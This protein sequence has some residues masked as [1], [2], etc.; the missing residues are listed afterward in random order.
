M[1]CEKKIFW[2]YFIILKTA[3]IKSKKQ[4]FKRRTKMDTF[5]QFLKKTNPNEVKA[6][7][8]F[9]QFLILQINSF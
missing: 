6:L 9:S 4:I 2:K 3:K 1:K 8:Q 5:N 7:R